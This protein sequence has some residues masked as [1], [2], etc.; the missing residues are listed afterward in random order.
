MDILLLLSRENRVT[1]FYRLS[2]RDPCSEVPPKVGSPNGEIISDARSLQVALNDVVVRWLQQRKHSGIRLWRVWLIFLMFFILVYVFMNI[3]WNGTMHS[4]FLS[5]SNIQ[6]RIF[7]LALVPLCTPPPPGS[8]CAASPMRT[9]MSCQ[10][11]GLVSGHSQHGREPEE[12]LVNLVH[13]IIYWRKWGF[14]ANSHQPFSF[15]KKINVYST[16]HF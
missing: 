4:H 16:W 14:R 11:E 2:S 5:T 8:S 10:N 13:W 9:Y 12:K 3:L 7:K 1:Y 6:G 15:F